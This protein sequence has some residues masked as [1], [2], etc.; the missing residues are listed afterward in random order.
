MQSNN[1]GKELMGGHIET[2]GDSRKGKKNEPKLK[3][4]LT[5]LL[6]LFWKEITVD[7]NTYYACTVHGEELS[8]KEWQDLKTKIGWHFSHRLI[9]IKAIGINGSY[10]VVYIKK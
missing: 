7:H 5:D 6:P 4:L 8:P 2:I 3:P 10:F 9:E 1:K